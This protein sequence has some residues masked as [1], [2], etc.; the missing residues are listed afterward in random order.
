MHS[1]TFQLNGLIKECAA[2]LQSFNK[3]HQ[4]EFDLQEPD[5][6][7]ADH[8]RIRQ[9]LVNLITNA[10]KY[11]PNGE[12]VILT[13]RYEDGFVKVL[14]QDFGVGISQNEQEKI[15]ER[16]Y[17]AV[18]EGGTDSGLGLGLYIS[19]EIIKRH[20]GT[21]G[22]VSEPGKGSTFYFTLP[23]KPQE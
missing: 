15:F 13:S 10:I 12:K 4:F 1:D 19:A 3:S 14:V 22:V 20:G 7:W 8:E 2:E 21:L 18:E 17:R 6:V 16:Y 23:A 11:S 5:T 9:T